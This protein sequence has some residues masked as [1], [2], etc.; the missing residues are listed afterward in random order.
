MF[1]RRP[2]LSPVRPSF[3][4]IFFLHFDTVNASSLFSFWSLEHGV[5]FSFP[6]QFP[7]VLLFDGMFPSCEIL[8]FPYLG[9]ALS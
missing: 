1:P 3:N 4:P 7:R 5:P 6:Y 9:L 2:V 8:C